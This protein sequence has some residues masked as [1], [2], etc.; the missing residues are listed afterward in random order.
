MLFFPFYSRY[1][2]QLSKKI[3]I[4]KVNVFCKSLEGTHDFTPFSSSGR[5]VEDTV[6]TVYS[7]FI[8]NEGDFTNLYISAD[9][10]L[11]NMV[12]IIVGTAIDVSDGRLSEY[13]AEEIFSTGKREKA[14]KTAPP[15]GLFL[16]KVFY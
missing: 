10:F 16:N 2:L 3:D 4:D 9:G 15:Q 13:C 1:S 5:T 7:C 12:R 6:R 11:Y 8:V 14:G